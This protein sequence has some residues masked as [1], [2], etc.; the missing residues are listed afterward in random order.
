L[1]GLGGE[2]IAGF[3]FE[4]GTLRPRETSEGGGQ[5]PLALLAVGIGA[6]PMILIYV[7]VVGIFLAVLYY[8]IMKFFPDPIKGYA[9]A[10]V[11]VIAAIIL[12]YLLLS[13]VGVTSLR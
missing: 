9:V 6:L 10:I 13:F 7:L 5:M 11:V 1:R 2:P 3:K 4:I 12:I 8:I